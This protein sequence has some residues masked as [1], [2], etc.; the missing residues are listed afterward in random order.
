MKTTIQAILVLAIL[1]LTVQPQVYAESK[2]PMATKALRMLI[3]GTV[4][5]GTST[6]GKKFIQIFGTDGTLKSGFANNRD[7]SDKWIPRETGTWRVSKGRIC[8]S[9]TKPKKRNG[10]CD[11]LYKTSAG[12]YIYKTS[13]GKW[14]SFD[15]IKKAN[16]P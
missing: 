7:S 14:G 16:T 6:S 15:K 2:I 12:R 10:G 8:N 9:Y 13:S 4:V 1:T 11:K 5:H 3:T